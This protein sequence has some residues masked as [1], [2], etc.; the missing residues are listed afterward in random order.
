MLNID[1]ITTIKKGK[2]SFDFDNIAIVVKQR[3]VVGNILQ[4]WLQGWLVHNGIEFSTNNNTQMPPDFFLDTTNHKESLLE[5]KAFNYN[6]SPGFDIA[7]FKMYENELISKPWMI[8]VD[9]LIFGYDMS[10]TGIVTIK[11]IWLKK[12]WEITAASSDWPLKLQVKR[13]VVHKLRPCKFFS[14]NSK[15]PVFKNES[16]FLSALEQTIYQ[17]PDTHSDAGTW[18]IRFRKAY[19]CEYGKEITIPRWEDIKDKYVH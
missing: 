11:K 9:Y 18:R 5:V 7:D 4:E 16:D 1:K 19:K 15:F 12:V 17:N 6:A 8:Y 14:S 3:D 13:N 10:N 2:I